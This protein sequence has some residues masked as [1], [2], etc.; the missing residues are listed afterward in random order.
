MDNQNHGMQQGKICKCPHHKMV[1]TLI[2]LGGLFLLLGSIGTF[3]MASTGVAIS[4][5]VMIG[6]LSEV[7]DTVCKCC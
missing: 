3:T 2:A 7:F 4:V 1:P 6:G 5:L